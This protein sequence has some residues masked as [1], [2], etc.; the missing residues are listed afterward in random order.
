[1]L[2]LMHCDIFL[3]HLNDYVQSSIANHVSEPDD[4]TEF[5]WHDFA[6]MIKYLFVV[7]H[8]ESRKLPGLLMGDVMVD[9]HALIYRGWY[10]PCT[11]QMAEK[12]C[13]W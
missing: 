13:T 6:L 8:L 7:Q 12:L 10:K 2:I 4:V 9:D 11:A 5:V 3:N 1:M